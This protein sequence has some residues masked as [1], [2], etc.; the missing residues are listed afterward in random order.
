MTEKERIEYMMDGINTH[1]DDNQGEMVE[2]PV[3]LLYLLQEFLKA[4]SWYADMNT[5]KVPY[6]TFENSAHLLSE[7][8]RN[9]VHECHKMKGG[10]GSEPYMVYDLVSACDT[11]TKL[12][13]LINRTNDKEPIDTNNY[14]YKC[15]M[16][17]NVNKFCHRLTEVMGYKLKDR[18]IT[19]GDMYVILELITRQVGDTLMID[20]KGYWKLI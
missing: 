8:L 5:S 17:G 1:L 14:L 6:P 19:D 15:Y 3:N 2:V 13:N 20:N 16:T 18:P 11:E 9:C 12:K 7:H 4:S 10:L